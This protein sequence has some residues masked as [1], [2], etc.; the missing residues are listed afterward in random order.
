M[1]KLMETNNPVL[2]SLVEALLTDANITYMIADQHMSIIEG[3]IALFPRRV[4]VSEDHLAR[5]RR[6]LYDADL[7]NELE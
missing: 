2:L 5:A 4:L 7:D 1:I 3:S 6:I